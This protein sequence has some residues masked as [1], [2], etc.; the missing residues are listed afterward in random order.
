[1]LR[2]IGRL[3]ARAS[4]G[5][6]PATLS[7]LVAWYDPSDL[8]SMYQ[9]SAG[10]TPAAVDSPVGKILDKSGGGHHATQATSD[11]R[12][13]LRQSGGVYY[14]EF[15]G[16][17]DSLE[18]ASFA[19]ASAS[20]HSSCVSAYLAA[21]AGTQSIMDADDATRVSQLIRSAGGTAQSIAFNTVPGAFT[22]SAGAISATTRT[23]LTQ[24]TTTSAVEVWV[25]GV[26]DGSTGITGTL[27]TGSV[28]LA[29]G[30]T[31]AGAQLLGGRIYKAAHYNVPLSSANQT[32]LETYIGA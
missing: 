12:P 20:G 9:D 26:S 23:T 18:T 4:G 25:N 10:T 14:L 22:D 27:Q 6:T 17:D 19:L 29:L 24:V 16:V 5:F 8:S 30:R 7:G 13:I 28:R 3:R 31:G 2:N 32:L 11:S 1:M 15:D 21:T